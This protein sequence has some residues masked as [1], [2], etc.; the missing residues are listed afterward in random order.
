MT[1]KT[2]LQNHDMVWSAS[3]LAGNGG[4]GWDSCSDDEYECDGVVDLTSENMAEN[5][6]E[7]DEEYYGIFDE[8]HISPWKKEST[9]EEA[10]LYVFTKEQLQTLE[11]NR[12]YMRE[13]LKE[14]TA[15]FE[16]LLNEYLNSC[17][18]AGVDRILRSGDA[19]IVFWDDGDKTVVKRAADEKDSDYV[20]FT[21]ALG[22]KIYG[23]NSKLTRFIKN[24]IEYQEKKENKT[25]AE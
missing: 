7:L 18:V 23:S 9:G 16:N 11:D 12:A 5:I 14:L 13:L 15:H 1:N 3:T 20:A 25:Y 8:G 24:H 4:C 6:A 2:V 21:A 10:E 19:M 22:K 17:E